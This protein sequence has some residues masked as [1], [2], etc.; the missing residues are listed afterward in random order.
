HNAPPT[1]D[2]ILQQSVDPATL[3]LQRV[4]RQVSAG[5]DALLF[6]I[7]G[8][9]VAASTSARRGD[10]KVTRIG[11]AS[12]QISDGGGAI[13]DGAAG[14]FHPS[15]ELGFDLWSRVDGGFV[16]IR[17]LGQGRVFYVQDGT[18]A[19]NR[20]ID[21]FDNAAFLLSVVADAAGPKRKV[22]IVDVL[23]GVSSEPSALGFIGPWAEAMGWQ[24]V[25]L[26]VVVAWTWG[27]RFGLPVAWRGREVG[28]REL[29]D[30]LADTMQRSGVASAALAAVV[31]DADHIVRRRAKLPMDAPVS[32]RNRAIPPSLGQ[33][34]VEAEAA[35]SE[36]ISSAVAL[37]LAKRLSV[38]LTRFTGDVRHVRAAKSRRVR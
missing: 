12:M 36:P 18:A 10:T 38:E 13:F 7:P 24:V 30:A 25:V 32:A 1:S 23:A 28:T 8:D 16:R 27:S 6:G 35:A 34:L 19:T 11:G 9:F 20:F 15:R 26:F 31:E 37:Q 5:S 14:F 22:A 21:Q 17:P 33:A 29:V 2:D 4:R 3:G